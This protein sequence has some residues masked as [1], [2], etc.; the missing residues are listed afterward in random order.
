MVQGDFHRHVLQVVL[1]HTFQQEFGRV[2]RNQ[3]LEPQPK[4]FAPAEVGTGQGGC[5]AQGLHRAVKN[6][7]P[8]AL[9]GAG[10]HVNHPVCCKHH[11]R[12]MLHHH[13]GIACIAQPLHGNDDAVHVTRVQADAGLVQHKQGVDQGRAQ[14]SG[15][16]DPLHL[17]ARKRA[18]LAVQGE[19][20]NAHLAQVFEARID[21][22]EQQGQSLNL[23]SVRSLFC[24]I[25]HT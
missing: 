25:R 1:G 24:V 15:Q 13:Q 17:A 4:L 11:G 2:G 10:A 20:S 3:V 6:N 19:V 9:A 18:A 22:V 5:A 21:F 12:V 16:V 23:P 8:S 14:G 7:G